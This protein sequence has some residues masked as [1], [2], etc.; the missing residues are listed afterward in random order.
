MPRPA[1]RYKPYDQRHLDQIPE[2]AVLSPELRLQ[3]RAVA[4]VLPFRANRYVVERLIAWEDVPNDPIFQLVFP[5]PGMLER[6]ALERMVELLHRGAPREALKSA[7]DEIRSEMNPHPAGQQT[8][9]VPLLEGRPMPGLQH[10]YAETVLFFPRQGQTCHAYCSY[11]FR[12]PQ[13]V[14]DEDLRFAASETDD[15]VQYVH[16]HRRVNNVLIT[17]GDPMVM[18]TALL[19]RYIEPLLSPELAHLTTIRIGS[20]AATYWPF[21]FLTDPD[22]D[23]LMRLFERITASGRHLAFMAHVTHPR[24]LETPEAQAAIRRIRS[25]G[26]AVRCQ[27]PIIRHVNDDAET[28]AELWRREVALGAVPYYMFVERDTGP[29]RY[30]ELPL[31]RSLEIFRDAFRHVSG[32]AR[33]VRG[34]SMSATPGKVVVDGIARIAGTDVL[35][36]RFMQA[37]VADWVGRPFFAEL[38][39]NATWLDQLRPAFGEKEFF[40][41]PT[42]RELEKCRPAASRRASLRVVDGVEAA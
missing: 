5:Q 37:R 40:F 25:T 23:D 26:A 8:L 32:L 27:A 17:G 38:D 35:A 7:A 6:P 3:M 24:E 31:V 30:F 14:G 2:I 16:A 42:L 10:K 18:R 13:F 12:W 22:A 4:S 39:P 11:C 1:P 15:L 19:A 9:N 34:P 33:T 20:K 29:K 36:L 41:E 28:W 21:R